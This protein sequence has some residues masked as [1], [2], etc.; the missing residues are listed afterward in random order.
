M[1]KNKVSL[2]REKGQRP[3]EKKGNPVEGSK[4]GEKNWKE[5][6]DGVEKGKRYGGEME[7]R[8]RIKAEGKGEKREKREA[9]E[10]E[11]GCREKES[12]L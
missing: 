10:T 6:E 7:G 11:G 1:N 8:K 3:N 2:V 9:R 12:F 5:R 4:N